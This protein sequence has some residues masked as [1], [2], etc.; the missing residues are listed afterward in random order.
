M[1]YLH[2]F[3]FNFYSITL[4]LE[5]LVLLDCTATQVVLPMYS[6]TQVLGLQ[7]T[8]FSW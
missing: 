1:E 2:L 7:D 3:Y 6:F 8:T 4:D 5:V